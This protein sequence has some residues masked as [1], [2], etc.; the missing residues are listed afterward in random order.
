MNLLV[1]TIGIFLAVLLILLVW[2]LKGK[3]GVAKSP[4]ASHNDLSFACKHLTNLPQIRQALEPA[5][6]V[7]IAGR[8]NG[9]AAKNV[10][11]ERRRIDP[12]TAAVPSLD[13]GRLEDI[14]SQVGR[15]SNGRRQIRVASDAAAGTED[16]LQGAL[17]HRLPRVGRE[18]QSRS[19]EFAEN[20]VHLEPVRANS[21][22]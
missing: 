16:E 15:E 6:L 20:L 18:K 8:S 2:S 1:F 19:E 21:P 13:R 10:R 14:L 4:V 9:R 12:Q 7:Y 3:T 5:D 22:G 17:D 11:Q